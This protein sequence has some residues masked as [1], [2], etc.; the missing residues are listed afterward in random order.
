M[1]KQKKLNVGLYL[2]CR[3]PKENNRPTVPSY[4]MPRNGFAPAGARSMA[5]QKSGTLSTARPVAFDELRIGQRN[6][7]FRNEY[8]SQSANDGLDVI[9]DASPTAALY[10]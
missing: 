3:T 5:S 10:A 7:K 4:P 6:C 2:R 1:S 8:C 9:H